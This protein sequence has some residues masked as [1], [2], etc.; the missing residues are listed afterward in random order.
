MRLSPT[1]AKADTSTIPMDAQVKYL[2]ALGD[3]TGESLQEP[4]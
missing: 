1:Q 4:P 2:I 3:F